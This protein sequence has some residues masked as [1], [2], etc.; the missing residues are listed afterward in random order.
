ML[1]AGYGSMMG[2]LMGGQSMS[3]FGNSTPAMTATAI[4]TL[5]EAEYARMKA[6]IQRSMPVAISMEER[7]RSGYVDA[8]T[9][10]PTLRLED[11]VASMRASI[12]GIR[13][14]VKPEMFGP[15]TVSGGSIPSGDKEKTM[16]EKLKEFFK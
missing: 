16:L 12:G 7:F 3:G 10:H 14:A 15:I 5:T 4:N 1:G 6:A 11:Y 13:N 9:G 2:G 8:T